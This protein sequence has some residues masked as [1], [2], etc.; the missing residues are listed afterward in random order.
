MPATKDQTNEH[1]II[2]SGWSINRILADEKTQTR[3]PLADGTQQCLHALNGESTDPDV[4]DGTASPSEL[5]FF[6]RE[7]A[8]SG[9]GWYACLKEYPSEGS[10]YIETCPY[11]QP[12]DILWVREAFRLHAANED[13][14][15]SSVIERHGQSTPRQYI[16]DDTI[17]PSGVSGMSDW[18]R[19]RPSI[20]MP[21]ELCRLR[22][23]VEGVRVER[24]QEISPEDARAEGIKPL[25]QLPYEPKTAFQAQ[26]VQGESLI[27]EF[28]D[29]WREIHGDGAWEENPFVWCVEFSRIDTE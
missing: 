13:E 11:G 2:F 22:L 25:Q 14:S 19:N 21:R 20:F 23:C 7:N 9:A 3:R 12:G 16:A 17:L 5:Q 15:P 4:Q 27:A 29:K 18:G 8:H 28:A 6:H 1:P 24:L 10:E 26:R